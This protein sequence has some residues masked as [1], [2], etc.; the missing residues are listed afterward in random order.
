MP[1]RGKMANMHRY[2]LRQRPLLHTAARSS[3]G[4]QLQDRLSHSCIPAGAIAAKLM[5]HRRIARNKTLICR[6]SQCSRN[7]HA[8]EPPPMYPMARPWR[9]L[10]CIKLYQSLL[11][12][13]HDRQSDRRGLSDHSIQ[14]IVTLTFIPGHSICGR[15]PSDLPS[16][17]TPLLFPW[18]SASL[19][20]L[21]LFGTEL[22]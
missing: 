20:H 9:S 11:H 8:M 1:P 2:H 12:E 16:W 17:R 21:S 19:L 13:C 14:G 10:S 18:T 3:Q 6:L 22:L 7:G 5:Q 4:P 15:R